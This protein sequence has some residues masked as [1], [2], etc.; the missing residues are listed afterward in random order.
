MTFLFINALNFYVK[1]DWI[2]THLPKFLDAEFV[3]H[4]PSLLCKVPKGSVNQ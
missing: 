3:K 2:K 4:I 1:L